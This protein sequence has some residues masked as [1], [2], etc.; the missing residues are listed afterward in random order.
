MPAFVTCSGIVKNI[1][2]RK[3]D[4]GSDYHVMAVE[5]EPGMPLI[6]AEVWSKKVTPNIYKDRKVVIAGEAWMIDSKAPGVQKTLSLS[7]RHI[8]ETDSDPFLALSVTG[9]L[10]RDPEIK[11]LE[12]GLV[13]TSFSLATDR[14]RQTSWWNM[15][16]FKRDA[17]NIGNYTK[18]GS[19]LGVSHA[20]LRWDSWEKEGQKQFKLKGTVNAFELMGKRNEESAPADD[21]PPE[22]IF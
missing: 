7:A 14:M 10:G 11:Y 12:S 18:K 5:V 17:E 6:C 1:A 9:K 3:T 2:P 22:E 4:K 13:I 8:C 15:V 19:L 21:I 20:I 16:A